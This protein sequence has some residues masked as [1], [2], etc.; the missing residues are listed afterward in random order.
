MRTTE[1]EELIFVKIERVKKEITRLPFEDRAGAYSELAD[2]LLDKM[3]GMTD[4]EPL[5]WIVDELEVFIEKYHLG[6]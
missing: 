1:Q 3:R 4:G 5:I 6:A 2:M